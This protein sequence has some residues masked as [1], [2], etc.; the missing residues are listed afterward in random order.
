MDLSVYYQKIREVEQ[1]IAEEFAVVVSCDSPDGGKSGTMTEVA[2]RLGAKLIVE[3]LARLASAEEAKAF[4][5]AQAEAKKAA[6]EIAAAARLQ[7][8]VV[9]T[10]ELERLRRGRKSEE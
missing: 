7:L 4:Q 10:A 2:R 6:E 5:E 3:G 1:R 8:A 9:P